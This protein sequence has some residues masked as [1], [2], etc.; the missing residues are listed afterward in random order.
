VNELRRFTNDPLRASRPAPLALVQLATLLRAQNHAAEAVAVL[1]RGREQ[2]EMLLAADPERAGW[3][4]LLRYHHGVALREAGKLAEARAVLDLVVK[5][6]SGRPEAV[7]AALRWG[8]CLKE[9]GRRRSRRPSKRPGRDP[10]VSVRK[11][12]GAS[13]GCQYLE[14]QAEQLKQKQASAD[15]LRPHDV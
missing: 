7:E 1:A 8:Q 9:E 2:Y 5:Q 13:R 15:L 14:A 10:V 11:E 12:S 4:S 3:V 6:A